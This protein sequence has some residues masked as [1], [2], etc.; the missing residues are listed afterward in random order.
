MIAVP[1]DPT[2]SADQELRITLAQQP[3]VLRLYW[4]TLVEFWFLDVIGVDSSK[5]L[6][7]LKLVP[8]LPLCMMS[9]ALA[10][11]SGDFMLVR[12][13]ENAPQKL[14]YEDLGTRWAL[15]YLTADELQAWMVSRGLA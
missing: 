14:A 11:I 6:R 7:S 13:D 10:P 9:R 8:P 5:S 15:C 3:V 12:R 4:N 2:V 1:F